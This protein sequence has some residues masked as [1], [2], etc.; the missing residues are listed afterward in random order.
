MKWQKLLPQVNGWLDNGIDEC[1]VTQPD[2]WDD[3]KKASIPDDL[4]EGAERLR[5]IR[6]GGGR[7][8]MSRRSS[9]KAVVSMRLVGG[10]G[11]ASVALTEENENCEQAGY[12]YDNEPSETYHGSESGSALDV[13]KASEI[14]FSYHLFASKPFFNYIIY[15]HGV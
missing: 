7:G 8:L 1:N 14:L 5:S 6:A 12:N 13:K 2:W 9:V 15:E 3:A 4:V 11:G 10:D